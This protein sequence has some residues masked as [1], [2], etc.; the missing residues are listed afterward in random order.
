[1]PLPVIAE[2]P[3]GYGAA[4]QMSVD[5]EQQ[6]VVPAAVAE[7]F[8]DQCGGNQVGTLAAQSLGYRQALHAEFR[9]AQ[10]R[11]VGKARE[12][13]QCREIRVQ[14]LARE[15]GGGLAKL[16][17]IVSPPELHRTC[18]VSRIWLGSTATIR[19]SG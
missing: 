14:F 18:S 7:G 6:P 17:L 13:I 8:E 2:L 15:L 12:M 9:A 16:T 10:P 4:P 3:D 19:A 11:L 1:M 5:G